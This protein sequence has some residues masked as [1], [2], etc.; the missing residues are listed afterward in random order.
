MRPT[1]TKGGVM[2]LAAVACLSVALD[3]RQSPPAGRGAGAAGQASAAVERGRTLFAV[4]CASCHG[5]DGRGGP[6]SAI[7]LSA[8]PIVTG[9][10]DGRQLAKFLETGRPARQM[11]AFALPEADAED[12]AAFLRA[13]AA[14]GRGRGRGRGP[15]A[16]VVGDANA[17][18]TYF[19]GEG[20]CT[21]CHSATGDLAGIGSRLEPATI[22]G[23]IL[24]P[25]GSGGYPPSFKSPP[26]PD[27]P[28]KTVVVTPASG[29]PVSGTLMWITDFNVTLVDAQGVRRTFARRGDE[30]KV[31]VTDPLQAHLDKM[32]TLTDE[33]LHDLTAYLVS[34]Q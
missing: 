13:P 15:V 7:D 2:E 32:R 4:H 29:P 28:K 26:N 14:A 27:D 21:T 20:G 34:L 6:L 3:S 12:L 19:N 11:P 16:E 8:S 23:R 18:E 33:H 9:D 25:R 30:P 24:L 5:A 10:Q 22:Q 1:A 31:E 17:G